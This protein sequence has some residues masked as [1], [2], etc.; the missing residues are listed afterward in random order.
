MRKQKTFY[1]WPYFLRGP[2]WTAAFLPHLKIRVECDT[3]D[4]RQFC[5]RK[6]L[7]KNGNKENALWIWQVGN[8]W[9]LLA[10]FH[11]L[12]A[13][14][15]T[16]PGYTPP[17]APRQLGYPISLLPLMRKAKFSANVAGIWPVVID[18]CLTWSRAQSVPLHCLPHLAFF[19]YWL[20]F[21]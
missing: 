3:D 7:K 15:S 8:D 13:L 20:E 18:P 17:L 1:I 14:W 21:F 12:I 9:I 4:R 10:V 16:C 6:Y 2:A 5:M 19:S 11:C